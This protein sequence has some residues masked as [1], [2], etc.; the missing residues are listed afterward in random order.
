[1]PIGASVAPNDRYT[2]MQWAGIWRKQVLL[3]EKWS[4][5]GEKKLNHPASLPPTEYSMYHLRYSM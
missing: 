5:V 4:I 1:M 2:D 3:G